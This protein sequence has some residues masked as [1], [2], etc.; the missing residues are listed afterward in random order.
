MERTVRQTP[1]RRV[2]LKP[3][4]ASAARCAARRRMAETA[5]WH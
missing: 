5:P 2:R 4:R 1:P 3:T